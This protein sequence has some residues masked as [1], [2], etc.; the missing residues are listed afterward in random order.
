MKLSDTKCAPS[1]PGAAVRPGKKY[2]EGSFVANGT[3][4]VD[5]G[6]FTGCSPKDN[7]IVKQPPSEDN[8]GWGPMNKP[9][10]AEVFD[11]LYDKAIK[12]LCSLDEC[13]CWTATVSRLKYS[14]VVEKFH[15]D[16]TVI[17]ACDIVGED[18]KAHGLNSEVFKHMAIIGG[19]FYGG[20]M[21]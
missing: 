11:A 19:T 8:V 18:W 15:L 12:N 16:F 10:T 17:N 20:E 13:T 5:T 6:K 1:H 14:S 4:A 2:N 7:F 3:F 9:T 21:K